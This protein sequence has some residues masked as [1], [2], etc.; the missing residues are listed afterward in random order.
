[1]INS[2]QRLE[3]N[4]KKIIVEDSNSKMKLYEQEALVLKNDS[5]ILQFQKDELLQKIQKMEEIDQDM[6]TLSS[7][8]LRL[9]QTL[10]A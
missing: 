8:N 7:E 4:D 10:Q 6:Q 3:L 5:Y 2:Q 9:E 1:M